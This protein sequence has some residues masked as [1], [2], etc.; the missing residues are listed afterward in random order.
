MAGGLNF[1]EMVQAE[2]F[3]F[4]K[5][6]RLRRKI[7]RA[8]LNGLGEGIQDFKEEV[9]VRQHAYCLIFGISPTEIR[10]KCTK[11]YSL[12]IHKSS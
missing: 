9:F 6:K 11:E 3:D 8:F 4:K 10:T 2:K 1:R 7:E 12:L 5:D